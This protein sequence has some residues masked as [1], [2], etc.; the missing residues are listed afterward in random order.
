MSLVR[1]SLP[2]S[3]DR[4]NS[5]A[6]ERKPAALVDS[7]GIGGNLS[8]NGRILRTLQQCTN[9]IVGLDG[10]S[11]PLSLSCSPMTHVQHGF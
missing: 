6:I 1:R 4:V 8:W 11:L 7:L 10:P 5:V 3:E 2:Y 9:V